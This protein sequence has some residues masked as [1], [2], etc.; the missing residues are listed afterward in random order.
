MRKFIG[1]AG[2]GLVGVSIAAVVGALALFAVIAA[3]IAAPAQ[4]RDPA[5]FNFIKSSRT[6]AAIPG[7]PFGEGAKNGNSRKIVSRLW[8]NKGGGG[9]SEADLVKGS[10]LGEGKRIGCNIVE[11]VAWTVLENQDFCS[12]EGTYRSA[13]IDVRLVPHHPT[14]AAPKYSSS[15]AGVGS[16]RGKMF[17]VRTAMRKRTSEIARRWPVAMRTALRF[18]AAEGILENPLASAA[19]RKQV[20]R[21]LKAEPHVDVMSGVH[22]LRGRDALRL[23]IEDRSHA[24]ETTFGDG[25][26]HYIT[27]DL[28]DA[29]ELRQQLFVD[30]SSFAVL[31]ERTILVGSKYNEFQ[32]WIADQGGNPAIVRETFTL[33][34]QV[35]EPKYAQRRI[36]CKSI[37]VE[38]DGVC[39]RIGPPGGRFIVTGG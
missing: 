35:R 4:A 25:A 26:G 1:K 12:H 38:S 9:E 36:P 16:L 21:L 33:P 6:Y 18:E 11:R 3:T 20:V 29:V 32:D 19:T 24:G 15:G 22:D 10:N 13:N 7:D 39:I 23:Q 2:L 30:P 8:I 34:R 14:S 17:R 27:L 28:R 31:S 5:A 37:N